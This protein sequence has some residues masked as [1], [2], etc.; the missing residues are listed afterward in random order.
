MFRKHEYRTI[1][2]F[3]TKPGKAQEQILEEMAVVYEMYDSK[4][5]SEFQRGR[6]RI[7]GDPV[8]AATK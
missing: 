1:I 4:V 2:K 3:L 7:K 8:T 5:S 6:Q